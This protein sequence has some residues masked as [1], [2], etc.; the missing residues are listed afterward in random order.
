MKCDGGV[1]VVMT[2][3]LL[4][5]SLYTLEQLATRPQRE[6][7][8]AAQQCQRPTLRITSLRNGDAFAGTSMEKA[9]I[10]GKTYRCVEEDVKGSV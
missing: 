7:S 5:G 3:L 10:A 2:G 8:A 1:G 9:A 6:P 4:S